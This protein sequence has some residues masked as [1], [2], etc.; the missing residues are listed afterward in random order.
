M[1]AILLHLRKIGLVLLPRD[2]SRDAVAQEYLPL[3]L[4]QPATL[5]PGRPGTL[6]LAAPSIGVSPRVHGVGQHVPQGSLIDAF[7]LQRPPIGSTLGSYTQAEAAAN[8]P[9]EHRADGSQ[10]G[11]ELKTPQHAGADLLIGVQLDIP[12]MVPDVADGQAG[13][14][15]P[16]PGLVTRA[17]EHALLE[18]VKFGFRHG[19]LEAQQQTVIVR[20]RVIETVAVAA[21]IPTAGSEAKPVAGGA[22]SLRW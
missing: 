13:D 21:I 2:V 8:H 19:A 22:A 6:A 17:L 3:L 7:P 11:K 10:P 16:A 18:D 1:G 20:C 12:G 15:F 5:P 14:K 4:R 9:L